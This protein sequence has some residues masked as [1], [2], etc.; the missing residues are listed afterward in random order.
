MAST[1]RG[2]LEQVLAGAPPRVAGH[3]LGGAAGAPMTGETSLTIGA[4][5]LV[6]EIVASSDEWAR[7]LAERFRS[8]LI[9]ETPAWRV[10]V[11]LSSGYPSTSSA[12]LPPG[13]CGHFFC[14][15]RET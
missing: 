7:I 8:F 14:V 6:N 1:R 2:A 3:A 11:R 4:G 5:G 10:T 9:A 13:N 15:T 12:T